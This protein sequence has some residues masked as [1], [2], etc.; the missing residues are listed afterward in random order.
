[1]ERVSSFKFLGTNISEDLTW[2]LKH[3]VPHKK[4]ERRPYF[5]RTLRKINLS[6]QLLMSFY[7]CTIKSVF[8]HGILMWYGN[9]SAVNKKA[10]Q[11]VLKAVQTINNKKLSSLKDIYTSH[12]LQKIRC[13]LKDSTHPAHQLFECLPSGK[14]YRP[15]K[16]RTTR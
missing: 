3:T 13:I 12:C 4:V 10:L 11:R 2:S 14:H 7:R 8:T 6:Q 5:L 9:S 1:M 15:I 16:A